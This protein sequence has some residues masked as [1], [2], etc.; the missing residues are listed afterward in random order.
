MH[1]IFVTFGG[2]CVYST[3]G[4][5]IIKVA[6][7]PDKPEISARDEKQSGSG[8]EKVHINPGYVWKQTDVFLVSD[9]Q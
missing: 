9:T 4:E 6:D 1:L 8:T 3:G 2:G 5:K 7:F